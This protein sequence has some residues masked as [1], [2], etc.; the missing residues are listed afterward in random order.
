MITSSCNTVSVTYQYAIIL[1]TGST[2]NECDGRNAPGKKA[3]QRFTTSLHEKNLSKIGKQDLLSGS[4]DVRTLKISTR[5]KQTEIS[6][7]LR[8]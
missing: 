7:M 3:A 4:V 2:F 5:S 6:I 8:K 1:R